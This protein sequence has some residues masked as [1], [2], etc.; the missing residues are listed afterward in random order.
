VQASPEA[1]NQVPQR[2]DLLALHKTITTLEGTAPMK[3]LFTLLAA[4]ITGVVIA[5]VMGD[6]D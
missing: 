6:D 1:K 5:V 3:T 2:N 4:A